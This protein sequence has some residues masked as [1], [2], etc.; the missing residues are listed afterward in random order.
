MSQIIRTSHEKEF[1]RITNRT[2]ADSRLSWRARGLLAYLLSKPDDW[3]VYPGHLVNAGP[4]GRTAVTTALRELQDCG[5][6]TRERTR[7][8]FG[9][10]ETSD[11]TIYEVPPEV[12]PTDQFP[13]AGEAAT[14][15]SDMS[16]NSI[17]LT[18]ESH[19][20]GARRHKGDE[21]NASQA[22]T[23]ASEFWDL[24]DP[25]PITPL[26]AIVERI[27]EALDAGHSPKSIQSILP[28]M[29]TYTRSAFDYLLNKETAARAK[30]D[31]HDWMRHLGAR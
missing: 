25:K 14:G 20:L 8:A 18:T 29:T 11:T 17:P 24:R 13:A 31:E 10:W 6:Y 7:N 12:E 5:Y 2:L 19:Q 28:E 9:C 30:E 4:E 23:I 15:E 21:S 26:T 3:H 22:Q 27:T 16:N 1:A